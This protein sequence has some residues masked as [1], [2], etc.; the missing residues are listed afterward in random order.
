M[1]VTNTDALKHSRATTD[2]RFKN[3][4]DRIKISYNE[5][6]DVQYTGYMIGAIN[7][8]TDVLQ[9]LRKENKNGELNLI[10]GDL[11]IEYLKAWNSMAKHPF[12]KKFILKAKLEDVV[13]GRD[14][15]DFV[16]L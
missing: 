14:V 13:E 2:Y 6:K 1:S 16:K 4:R 15:Q 10:I 9:S 8:F 12:C 3:P 5:Y 7:T 11:E